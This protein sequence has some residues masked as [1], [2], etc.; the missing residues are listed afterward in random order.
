MY[1]G[2]ILFA[3]QFNVFIS[4]LWLFIAYYHFLVLQEEVYYEINLQLPNV[5]A[6]KIYM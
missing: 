2:T 6:Y 3:V 5:Q 1:L 4:L